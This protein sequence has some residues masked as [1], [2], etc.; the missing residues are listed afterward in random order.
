MKNQIIHG[1]CINE[2]QNMERST[3]H[4]VITSPPY[5]V[6]LGNNK[7]KKDGYNEHN[8]NMPYSEYLKWMEE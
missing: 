4:C 8:D 3:I 6:D 7:Y 5:N 2:L 1:D